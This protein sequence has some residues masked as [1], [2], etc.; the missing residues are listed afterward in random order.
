LAFWAIAV[1][2]YIL[3]ALFRMAIILLVIMIIKIVRQKPQ[4]QT[5]KGE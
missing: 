2:D 4:A 5:E 3:Y 1:L